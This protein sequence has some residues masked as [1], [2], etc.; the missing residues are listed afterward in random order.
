MGA[1]IAL[2]NLLSRSECWLSLFFN[3]KKFLGC[4]MRWL[5]CFKVRSRSLFSICLVSS[6]LWLG[7]RC[8][9]DERFILVKLGEVAGPAGLWIDLLL[10]PL[11]SLKMGTHWLRGEERWAPGMAVGPPCSMGK[12]SPWGYPLPPG[13]EHGCGLDEGEAGG[14][15]DRA[16]LW[17]KTQQWNC[18]KYPL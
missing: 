13:W 17:Q 2:L 6:A 3:K 5:P 11:R 16:G 4:C 1:V 15:H 14:N 7:W 12:R 8:V 10:R 18:L 9:P